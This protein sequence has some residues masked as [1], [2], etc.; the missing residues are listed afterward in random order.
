[1]THLPNIRIEKLLYL[2]KKKIAYTYSCSSRWCLAVQVCRLAGAEFT[3]STALVISWSLILTCIHLYYLLRCAPGSGCMCRRLV[4][5][6]LSLGLQG[7]E[8]DTLM[9]LGIHTPQCN[10]L[11]RKIKIESRSICYYGKRWF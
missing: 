2:Y 11:S 4:E 7:W 10:R 8:E 3:W 9:F 1:M 6:H 5:P